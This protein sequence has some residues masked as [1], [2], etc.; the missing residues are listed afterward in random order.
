MYAKLSDPG[1]SNGIVR[2][3]VDDVL[4]GESINNDESSGTLKAISFITNSLD[5]NTNG[6]FYIDD[7]SVFASS[8]PDSI[9]PVRSG[10]SPSGSLAAGTTQTYISLNTDESA[11][12]RYSKFRNKL[13]ING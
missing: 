13:F 12:C 4:I 7:I 8:G 1:Q 2:A 5:A 6:T 3:Y 10:G 9:P 11:T